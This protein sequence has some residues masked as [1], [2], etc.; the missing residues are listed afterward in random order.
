MGGI[1][2]LSDLEEFFLGSGGFIEG[3]LAEVSAAFVGWRRELGYAPVSTGVQG[4]LEDQLRRLNPLT[5]EGRPREV[6][7]PIAG[8][9][10]YFD[11]FARASDPA[12]VCGELAARMGGRAV[13]ARFGPV[14]YAGMHIPTSVQFHLWGPTGKPPLGYVRAIDAVK[15]SKWIFETSGEP[16]SFEEI[17]NYSKRLVRDRFTVDMLRRYC[18]SLGFDPYAVGSYSSTGLLVEST[19]P[20]MV[21]NPAEEVWI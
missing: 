13:L 21:A 3:S 10:A 20:W 12:S 15:D 16:L 6:L 5:L 1:G 7:V 19:L 18:V 9:V 14:S 4:R 17:E 11:C 2:D 8:W